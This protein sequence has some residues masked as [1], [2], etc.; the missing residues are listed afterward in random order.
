MKR[1]Y[2]DVFYNLVFRCNEDLTDGEIYYHDLKE[3]VSKP[4]YIKEIIIHNGDYE[5]ISESV[6]QE[7]IDRR[8]AEFS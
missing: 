7:I 8:K 1:Y 4:L 3:W 5:D 2:T 6:A